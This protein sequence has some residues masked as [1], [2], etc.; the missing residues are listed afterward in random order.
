MKRYEAIIVKFYNRV[1][2]T[3]AER[4]EDIPAE[5]LKVLSYIKPNDLA[6][7]FIIEDLQA[8]KSPQQISITYQIPRGTI[9]GIGRK[10]RI[11][12]RNK[13]KNSQ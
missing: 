6:S 8:G 12:P 7:A 10:Y 9:R 4:L 13:A 2:Q 1:A 11:L 5:S 3:D